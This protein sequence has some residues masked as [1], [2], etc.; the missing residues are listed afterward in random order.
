MFFGV[1][2]CFFFPIKVKIVNRSNT[3]Y[4]PGNKGLFYN[5]ISLII[6]CTSTIIVLLLSRIGQ[7]TLL[8]MYI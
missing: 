3:A 1:Q 5:L 4:A 8:I 6:I 2:I 7:C